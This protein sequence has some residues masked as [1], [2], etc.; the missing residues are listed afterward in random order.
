MAVR[1]Y[2]VYAGRLAEFCDDAQIC[3]RTAV[4]SCRMP[5]ELGTETVYDI[6]KK[7]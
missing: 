2:V 3:L 5:Y 4:P 1:N 7:H 6:I